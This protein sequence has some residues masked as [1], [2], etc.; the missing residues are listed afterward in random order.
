MNYKKEFYAQY[1]KIQLFLL[2]KKENTS[3]SIREIQKMKMTIEMYKLKDKTAPKLMWKLYK[4]TQNLY[5]LRND[6]SFRTR[7]FK[8]VQYGTETLSFMGPKIEL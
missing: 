5:N 6:H 2:M 3:Q 4:K 8:I 1:I 7:N